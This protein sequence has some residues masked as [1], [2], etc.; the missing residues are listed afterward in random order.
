MTDIL[1]LGAGRRIIQAGPGERVVQHD[2]TRHSKA[3]DVAWDLNDLPWPWGDESFDQIV[4]CAV[5]EHLRNTLI[6][7]VNECWRIV[8]PGGLLY[9][10]L[11]YW[12][13]DNAFRD[14]THYWQ[15]A[16][17]TCDLFDPETKYGKDYGFYG[18][19]PW[20]IVQPAKLNDAGTSFAVKLK[21]RK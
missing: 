15:F 3:I 21:A 16:L 17:D 8:R 12:K 18:V 2:R 9:M 5:F 14:P 19:R 7:T 4:A 11:P 6:E 13:S 20:Q 1:N 10:K